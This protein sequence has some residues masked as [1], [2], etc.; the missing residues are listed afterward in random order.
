[1]RFKY[2]GSWITTDGRDDVDV[3]ERLKNAAQQFGHLKKCVFYT[4]EVS[5][6][7]KH[8]VYTSLVRNAL[9]Y[10]SES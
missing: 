2:L 8:A 4:T 9:L 6:A 10:G 7:A 3:D 1:M 5:N